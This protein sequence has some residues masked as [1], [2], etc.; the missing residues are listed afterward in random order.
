MS[1]KHRLRTLHVRVAGQDDV[2]IA[3]AAADHRPLHV[4]QPRDNCVNRL[5]DPETQIGRDLVVTAAGGMELASHIADTICEG[6][7]HMHV[8]VFKLGAKREAVLLDFFAYLAQ[9]LFNLTRFVTGEKANFGEHLGMRGR[10][11]DIVRKQAAIEAQ[12]FR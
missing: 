4:A 1:G 2:G 7:L 8:D 12:H 9:A 5:A 10:S 3:I 6:L 11:G